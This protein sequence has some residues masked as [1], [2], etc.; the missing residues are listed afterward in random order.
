[1][2]LTNRPLLSE[3]LLIDAFPKLAEKLPAASRFDLPSLRALV[4]SPGRAQVARRLV[5]SE[6]FDLVQAWYVDLH[7]ASVA[8]AELE[9]S[10]EAVANSP[11]PAPGDGTLSNSND[12]VDV[13]CGPD[14]P[15]SEYQ[16]I[17]MPVL[18]RSEAEFTRDLMQQAH[19]RLSSG[20]Y[21]AVAVDNPKD[22]WL[23][24]QMKSMFDKVTSE[25]TSSGFVFWARKTNELKKLKSFDCEF[26]FKDE[27][28]I[29]RVVTLP[30]VFSHR[31]LDHGAKQLMLSA[32]VGPDDNVLDMGCGSGSVA[33]AAAFKTTGKVFGVDS[34]ARAIECL[35]RGAEMNQLDNVEAIWNADGNLEFDVEIDLALANPPYYGNDNISQHFVDTAIRFM[36]SGGALLVV[37]KQP[38][39]Y[40]AYFEGVGLED[41]AIF[42]AGNYFV[43]CGR[44]T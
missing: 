24:D 32:D 22:T 11:S 44:K 8:A 38:N 39:W 14:L 16:L 2:D 36:R 12:S 25:R 17:V 4:I 21:L 31:R 29:I 28:N 33:L 15:E 19:Q 7:D 27:Q 43:A 34:N 40:E 23:H 13:L 37:T 41:I 10:S 35:K 5:E 9:L 26:T 1:M 42:E 3:Q 20:G 6:F 18:K 30:S